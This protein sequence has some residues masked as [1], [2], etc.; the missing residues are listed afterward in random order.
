MVLG[1]AGRHG[2]AVQPVFA[3]EISALEQEPAPTLSQA[4]TDCIAMKE[5]AR[6]NRTVRVSVI[7]MCLCLFIL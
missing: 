5:K 1:P 3:R 2:A 4:K 7:W 6:S